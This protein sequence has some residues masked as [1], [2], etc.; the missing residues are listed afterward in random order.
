MKHVGEYL[1]EAGVLTPAQVEAVLAR[2]KDM[3]AR[4]ETKRFGEVVL[5]LGLATS[6]QLQGA[7]DRQQRERTPGG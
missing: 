1:I 4:G 6:Q 7:I 5:A 3:A 2:Q